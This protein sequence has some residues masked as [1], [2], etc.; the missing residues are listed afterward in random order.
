MKKGRLRVIRAALPARLL[1]DT[2]LRAQP[3]PLFQTLVCGGSV[4]TARHFYS[5]AVFTYVK[6]FCLDGFL[7]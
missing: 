3:L 2:R 1:F 6:I 5:P 4:Y 7:S